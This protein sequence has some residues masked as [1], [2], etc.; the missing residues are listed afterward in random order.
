MRR[1]RQQPQRPQGA[2]A[3]SAFLASTSSTPSPTTHDSHSSELSQVQHHL[4]LGQ[5]VVAAHHLGQAG[6][7]RSHHSAVMPAV[8]TFLKL[9]AERRALWTRAD[10]RHPFCQDENARSCRDFAQVERIAGNFDG[11]FRAAWDA[12]GNRN[13]T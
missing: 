10:K 2:G 5:Q 3:G 4:L 7:A 6:E 11:A 9:G 13:G 8:D 12:L 1:D